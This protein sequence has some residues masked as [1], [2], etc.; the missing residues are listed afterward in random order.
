M[1]MFIR[2]YGP[3]MGRRRGR[4][5]AYLSFC[6]PFTGSSSR[7]PSIACASRELTF[8]TLTSSVSGT[9]AM[10]RGVPSIPL[11]IL[12]AETRLCRF[13]SWACLALLRR[14]IRS[15][16]AACDAAEVAFGDSRCT[17][18]TKNGKGRWSVAHD[19]CTPFATSF[20]EL[21][22]ACLDLKALFFYTT[23]RISCAFRGT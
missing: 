11:N 3:G 19:R 21:L 22:V 23:T 10:V 1:Y 16:A 18:P 15:W 4:I 12:V 8:R 5:G 7:V 20:K 13:L 17:R 6:S 14:L 2:E 9:M